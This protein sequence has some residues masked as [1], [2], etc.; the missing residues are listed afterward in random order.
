MSGIRWVLS[1]CCLI[2]P[3]SA[4]S[5]LQRG[6]SLRILSAAHSAQSRFERGRRES[7]P[8]VDQP[9][10]HPCETVIGRM[11]HWQDNGDTEPPP[12]S[13][14]VRRARQ[15]LIATLAR[16]NAISPGDDWI[17]G[18]RVRYMIEAGEDSAA[19]SVARSC[20]PPRWY[21]LALQGYALH[22]S[23]QYGDAAAAFDSALAEMPSNERCR[24]NDI[25]VLLEDNE[26][27][28]YN[29]LPCGR[30]DSVEQR[31]WDLAQPSFAVRGNDRRTEHF[32]RV[33]LADLYQTATN[34]YGLPWGPDMREM[35]IRYGEPLWYSVEWPGPFTTF[36][37]PVG[38]DRMPSFHFAAVVDGDNVRW[39]AY[40]Q[41]ARERYAP[42]YIDTLTTLDAQFAMMKRGDSALVV[43]V[44]SDTTLGRAVLGVSGTPAD[45][46]TQGVHRSRVRRARSKWKAEMVAMEA[47]DPER[48]HDAR[49]REWLAPPYHA[50]GA[51]DLSTLLLFAADTGVTVESLDDALAHALT[52]TDLRGARR[53][54]LYW[55]EYGAT[56]PDSSS[57]P[58]VTAVGTDSQSV[59]APD[60]SSDSSSNSLPDS[61]SESSS[62][63]V[64]VTR[65]DGGVLRWLGQALHIT[66]RD[67]PLAVR[68]HDTYATT[69]IAS[70]SVVLDLAQLPAGTYQVSV[71]VGTD[72]AHRTQISRA[73]K[74]R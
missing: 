1:I 28:G 27:D 73:I 20:A 44:Y 26:R 52:S 51:P 7:L 72:D 35:L 46:S 61:S 18:E 6:D 70:H 71:A 55:E 13:R 21:C 17:A 33:L 74:L 32:S 41:V 4:Q 24:W 64:T 66:G 3:A 56:K 15:A 29:A 37:T 30:R 31:F 54:G 69:G 22:M 60:S 39:D 48:L 50:L 10:D 49:A 25:S 8:H 14:S 47:F 9:N 23:E 65:T 34:A 45:T 5:Q 12:E 16:L 68:W 53:L 11:C 62:V 58:H 59:T 57:G 38:H 19:V 43:A 63:L 40:A 42:P 36:Q 67:S 2:V